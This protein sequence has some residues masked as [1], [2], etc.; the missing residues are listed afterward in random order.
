MTTPTLEQRIQALED[1]AA[2][3]HLVDTFSNLADD[4]NVAGQ[5]P[6]FTEDASVE[7]Y[8]GSELFAS[9]KGREQIA[10]VFNSFLSNFDTVYHIN[11]QQTVQVDGDSATSDHYCMVVLISGAEGNRVKN[12]NGV[13]YKDTYVRRDGR[14]LISKRVARFT[15]RDFEPM[16]AQ[17]A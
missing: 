2:L 11:G 3:K 15:W 5:M 9:L 8:F 6:L 12:T 1:Q 7:T 13:I 17:S 10:E 14:W 16:Q 4:K